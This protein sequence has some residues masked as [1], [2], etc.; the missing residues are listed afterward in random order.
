ML[1]KYFPF[2]ILILAALLFFWIK[3]NQRGTDHS[4][5]N[6]EINAEPFQRDTKTITYSRHARCRMKCRNIDESEVKEILLNGK[7]NYNKVEEDQQGKTY[8]LEGITHDR[9]HVRLVVAPKDNNL[10]VVTV[11]DLDKEWRCDC[12]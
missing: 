3:K 7:I 12:N 1:R 8:P 4:E 11:V 6:K 5:F 9:Q 10:V 2:I